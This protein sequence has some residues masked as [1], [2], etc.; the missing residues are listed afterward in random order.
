MNKDQNLLQHQKETIIIICLISINKN[1]QDLYYCSSANV[2]TYSEE[3]G[4]IVI[5]FYLETMLSLTYICNAIEYAG[6]EHIRKVAK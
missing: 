4:S 1:L 5:L 2:L 6:A 3:S